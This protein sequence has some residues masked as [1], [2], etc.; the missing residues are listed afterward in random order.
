LHRFDGTEA[1]KFDEITRYGGTLR[2]L[3]P[4]TGYLVTDSDDDITRLWNLHGEL[5]AEFPGKVSTNSETFFEGPF[6][7]VTPDG[8]Y[9]ITSLDDTTHRI[10]PIDNGLDDLL[11]RACTQLQPYFRAN[12][13]IQQERGICRDHPTP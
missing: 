3:T 4:G 9:I 11:H 5:L 10:W 1:T 6:D 13:E 2:E 8:R 12:P 7:R